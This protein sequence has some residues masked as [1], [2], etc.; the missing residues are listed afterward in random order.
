M[1]TFSGKIC[2]VLEDLN[3][4]GNFCKKLHNISPCGHDPCE[5]GDFSNELYY[6]TSKK[7]RSNFAW[8]RPPVLISVKNILK[9]L[10][11][12][13]LQLKIKVTV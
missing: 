13:L 7:K 5:V 6:F 11:Q 4:F 10:I 8:K 2:L 1:T 12:C 9:A 3:T